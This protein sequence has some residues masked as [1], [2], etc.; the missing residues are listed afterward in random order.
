MES[1]ALRHLAVQELTVGEAATALSG[2]PPR[3]LCFGGLGFGLIRT[4][5][6]P[7]RGRS[8]LPP[9]CSRALPR[10]PDAS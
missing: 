10:L 2:V 1:E 3:Q 4:L 8:R 5:S 9:R 6:G 7:R